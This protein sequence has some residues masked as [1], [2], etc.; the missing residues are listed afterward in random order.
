MSIIT[1]VCGEWDKEV[2]EFVNSQ[3]DGWW[4]KGTHYSA[5]KCDNKILFAIIHNKSVKDYRPGE[6][7]L[8]ISTIANYSEIRKGLF[9]SFDSSQRKKIRDYAVYRHA[10]YAFVERGFDGV[11][12]VIRESDKSVY[13]LVNHI[14]NASLIDS[15]ETTSSGVR[16]LHWI[17]TKEDWDLIQT[18][19]FKNTINF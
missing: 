15:G 12:G 5:L 8:E 18:R 6:T 17:V 14:N 10:H 9:G 16:L 7:W 2:E 11:Y 1:T 13:N 3:D 4:W 19:A